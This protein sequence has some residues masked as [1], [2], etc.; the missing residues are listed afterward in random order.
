MIGE[1]VATVLT[2]AATGIILSEYS[3]ARFRTQSLS[4]APSTQGTNGS[5][6]KLPSWVPWVAVGLGVIGV[7]IVLSSNEGGNKP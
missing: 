5:G 2:G 1:V 7:A 6:T 3:N 4:G